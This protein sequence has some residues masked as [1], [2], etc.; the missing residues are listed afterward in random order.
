MLSNETI[1]DH[2]LLC[3]FPTPTVAMQHPL[4]PYALVF[5]GFCNQFLAI[6]KTMPTT[7]ATPYPLTLI[8]VHD[9]LQ[10]RGGTNPATV[11]SYVKAMVGT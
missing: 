1:L 10:V 4:W 7:P 11:K 6:G 2:G 8:K 9:R 5:L 3:P